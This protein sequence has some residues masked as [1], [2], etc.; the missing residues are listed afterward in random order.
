MK[1][2]FIWYT[3]LR[4]IKEF[5]KSRNSETDNLATAIKFNE[6]GTCSGSG[7]FHFLRRDIG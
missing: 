2:L 4:Q 1:L 5:S 7:V 3:K 6:R